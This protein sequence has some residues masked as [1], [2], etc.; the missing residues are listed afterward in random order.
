MSGPQAPDR[1]ALTITI[2]SVV[3]A[4]MLAIS[5]TQFGQAVAAG[6][7]TA[8]SNGE[9]RVGD[10]A[11][12]YVRYRLNSFSEERLQREQR[13]TQLKLARQ[14]LDLA[15]K[16]GELGNIAAMEAYFSER[17]AGLCGKFDGLAARVT[18]DLP[19]RRTIQAGVDAIRNEF[20][21]E[22]KR[23]ADQARAAI[24]GGKAA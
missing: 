9:F 21:A 17:V 22:C 16:R 13:L 19:L 10:V 4:E 1:S 5:Q 14:S 23:E 20:A 15:V 18:R 3:A 8:Q 6:W 24:T 2:N 12:G 11:T 7:I